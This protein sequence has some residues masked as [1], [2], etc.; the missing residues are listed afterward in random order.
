MVC[1]LNV[2]IS[3][4]LCLFIIKLYSQKNIFKY[5]KKKHGKDIYNIIRSFENLKTKYEKTKLDIQYIKLCKQERLLPTFATIKLSIQ[6][7]N[8]KLK[9]RIGRIIM[10]HEL[11]R[12]H[13]EKKQLK[14]EIKSISIQLKM[15]LSMIIY[16]VLLNKINI[17]IRSR[18]KVIKL[19]HNKKICNLR[20]KHGID[21]L[22]YNKIPKNIIHN[23]STY[24]LTKDEIQALS[25]GLDQHVPSNP[26]RYKINTDFEYF[27]QNILNDISDLPQHHLDHI[28]TK[29]R[30][31]C[32]K[33]HNTR[34]TNKYKN[35][36]EKL[37]KNDAIII[38][39]QDKGRGV[40]IL[41]HTKY[42]DKCLSMLGTKQFS[43][44]DSDPTSKLESKIQRTLR[45]IKSKLPEKVYRKLYPTGSCPGK[46]Y[47]NAKVHKLLTNNVDDLPL[48]PIIS[49]IG[50]ATYETAK[51]L[52]NLLAPLGKSKYTITNTK[53]F[54]KYI[55]KQKVPDGY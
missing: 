11:E 31:T 34:T 8:N 24:D 1:V 44:L 12:K 9:E 48:R 47:G 21:K 54:V 18:M 19:R 49:N 28:K 52:A 33:Y 40:V 17:D 39:K 37:S 2:F 7:K 16:S 55:Q 32:E 27:Y 43:K 14:K 20:K 29:L 51:Y 3:F 26:E 13:H 22:S 45:K 25:Y 15:P 6:T 46:F 42:I 36:I 35:V 38:A 41:D 53:E 5:I 4:W 10:E 30:S 50:I 23:F